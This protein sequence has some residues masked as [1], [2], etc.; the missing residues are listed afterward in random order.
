MPSTTSS[1]AR[2]R[3]SRIFGGW[4]SVSTV[5]ATVGFA[6]SPWSFGAF[7]EVHMTTSEPF[8]VKAIGTLRGVPSLAT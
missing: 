7:L 6:R 5:R 8:H 1:S 2:P 3:I 4:T